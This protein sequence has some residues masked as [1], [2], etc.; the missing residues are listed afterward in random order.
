MAS[1]AGF[2][3][4]FSETVTTAIADSDTE[5]RTARAKVREIEE[6]NGKLR[7]LAIAG[8]IVVG[9]MSIH[10]MDATAADDLEELAA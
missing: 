2:L 1:A 10:L 3:R 5:L 8:G 4:H 6:E 7:T 9:G